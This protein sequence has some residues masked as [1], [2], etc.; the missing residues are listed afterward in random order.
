M[1][2]QYH[3]EQQ[4]S[5]KHRKDHNNIPIRQRDDIFYTAINSMPEDFNS[6]TNYY[7]SDNM[8]INEQFIDSL[9]NVK[10]KVV[11]KSPIPPLWGGG[12]L[13]VG[14]RERSAPQGYPYFLSFAQ[15]KFLKPQKI[16]GR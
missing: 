4:S 16:E 1:I 3:H 7:P 10:G 11:P 12:R 6:N 5:R 8:Q 9:F 2:N 15:Q 13:P 14:I